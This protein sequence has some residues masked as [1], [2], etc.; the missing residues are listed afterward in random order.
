MR[1][2]LLCRQEESLVLQLKVKTADELPPDMLLIDKWPTGK[3]VFGSK[4]G[5][6]SII[7]RAQ[8]KL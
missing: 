3:Q 5:F 2:K 7:H 6:S 8:S 1:E 4:T